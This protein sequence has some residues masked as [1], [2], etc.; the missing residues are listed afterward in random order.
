[1]NGAVPESEPA[2]RLRWLVRHGVPR[3]VLK[4][5]CATGSLVARAMSGPGDRENPYPLYRRMRERGAVIGNS[6]SLAAVRFS[7]VDVVLR[8]GRFT[9]GPAS[10]PVARFA[11]KVGRNPRAI[12]TLDPPSMFVV[13]PPDHTR[14]RKVVSG[15]FTARTVEA[16][17]GRIQELTDQLLDRLVEAGPPV[18]LV[19]AYCQ[20]LPVA[21][22][23]DVMGVPSS[24]L[25]Q[26]VE[27]N[28]RA[29]PALDL[30]LNYAD[31]CTSESALAETNAWLGQHLAG[32][33]G[34]PPDTRLGELV[35]GAA[36]RLTEPELMAA[37]QVLLSAGFVTL[38]DALANGVVLLLEH[39][40]Q[41]A[42]LRRDPSG[43]DNAV[44][45][46]LRFE[47]PVQFTAR[48]ADEDQV[49]DGCPVKRGNSVVAALGAAN[50]DPA[51][52]PDPDRFDITR[53]NARDHLAFSRGLHFCVG[54]GLARAEVVI[55]LRTLFERFPDLALAGPPQR[56][57]TAMLRGFSQLPVRLGQPAPAAARR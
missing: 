43:W 2:R 14:Y 21:V 5:G 48:F 42:A 33:A 55:G 7:A 57:P 35:H 47:S 26:F 53:A 10:S 46:I 28:D 32:L 37:V 15:L 41:L 30:G 12:G 18:D 17:S 34:R 25:E 24:M 39:P 4:I 29:A 44:E 31:F 20:Q 3:L 54:A 16:M 9:A 23:A 52:F 49:V 6:L 45:E 56:R 22:I 38:V 13:D 8:D 11:M 19:T 36:D 51:A 27:W 40:D 1:M 50:R